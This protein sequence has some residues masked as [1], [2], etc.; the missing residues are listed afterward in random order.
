MQLASP[1]DQEADTSLIASSRR[2]HKA[3]SASTGE[4]RTRQTMAGK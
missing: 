3:T 4:S 1:P 2:T